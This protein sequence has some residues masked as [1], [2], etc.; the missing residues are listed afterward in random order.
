MTGLELLNDTLR[1]QGFQQKQIDSKI[2]A[3]VLSIIADDVVFIDLREEK[4]ELQNLK[5]ERDFI[6]NQINDL[7]NE[8]TYLQRSFQDAQA[9]FYKE[10]Q[11]FVASTFEIKKYVDNFNKSL[12]ECDTDDG[13]DAMRKAQ[14]FINQCNIDSKYDNTAFIIGLS[15]ILSNG[16]MGP[17][18]DL[19]KINPKLF[20]FGMNGGKK[21]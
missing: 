4:I 6:E 8:K 1:K 9:E 13:K 20:E 12:L 18:D 2:V 21:K 10:K 7:K 14:L 19:K 5:R 11:E 17:I 3:S 15:Q 16:K